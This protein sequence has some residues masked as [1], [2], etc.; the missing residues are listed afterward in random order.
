MPI[1][2]KPSA[3][4]I[5]FVDDVSF[6]VMRFIRSAEYEGYQVH[7]FSHGDDLLSHVNENEFHFDLLVLDLIMP[8]IDG[9]EI[10]R[11]LRKRY[12]SEELPV[13]MLSTKNNELDAEMALL[14]GANVFFNKAVSADEFMQGVRKLMDQGQKFA[15]PA[16]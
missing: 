16:K 11:A 7:T 10:L 15:F 1:D 14:N 4:R 6:S 5:A 9:L 12:T 8:D 13:I 3:G 2:R